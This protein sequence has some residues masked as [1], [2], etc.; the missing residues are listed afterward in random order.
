MQLT[1][2]VDQ[3]SACDC[4]KERAMLKLIEGSYASFFP[5]EIDA[6]FRNRAETFS[7]RLGWDVVVKDGYERDGFDD[8]NPL[9]LVSVDADIGVL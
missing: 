9:Y 6:M 2:R 3:P 1:Q 5:K 4:K 7:E 8:Q